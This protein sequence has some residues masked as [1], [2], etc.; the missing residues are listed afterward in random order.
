MGI[1]SK[2]LQDMERTSSVKATLDSY[3]SN[4]PEHVLDTVQDW[5]D[6]LQGGLER[7]V[8]HD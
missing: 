7:R 8:H 3:R 5:Y 2:T 4:G 6:I 1:V